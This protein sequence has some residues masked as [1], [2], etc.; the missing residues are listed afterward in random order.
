MFLEHKSEREAKLEEV[1]E[2]EERIVGRGGFGTVR[3]ARLR[4]APAVVRAVKTVWKRNLKAQHLVRQEIDILR[5][6]DH[7]CICRL[8]ETFEDEKAIYLVMEFIDG[9]E[10]FDEIVESEFLAEGQAAMIMRQVFSALQYCHAR[11]VVHRDL[12]PDNLMV[13]R[14]EGESPLQKEGLLAP[15]VKLIDF[16]LAVITTKPAMR[17]S[18]TGS[19]M[20]GT[21]DYMAPEVRSRQGACRPSSDVWSAGMV[22]HAL[23]VGALPD[24]DMMDEEEPLAF[25][26]AQYARVS[27]V[28]KDLLRGLLQVDPAKRLTAIMAASHPFLRQVDDACSPGSDCL[29]ATLGSFACFH[30][31][32]KLRRAALTAVAMQLT[33]HQLQHLRAQFMQIDTDG[34]GRISKEELAMSIALCAPGG[35]TESVHC[36][37]EMVFDSLDTDGSQEIDYTEWLAAALEEGAYRSEEALRAA[38]RVFDTD[39]DGVI[40]NAELGKLLA[41]SPE[42][43]AALLPQ[44]DANGDGVLDFEEFKNIFEHG[45]LP[46]D[47]AQCG[48]P[49]SP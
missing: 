41:E 6:L 45:L 11:N 15:E 5:T 21:A 49:L 3:K 7:P 48:S 29:A 36:F 30:K 19:T 2:V 23:L 34:N 46:G 9:R 8:Y 32:S 43:I 31:A 37:V 24:F 44:F 1:Y 42:E 38:F 35:N 18:T 47:L 16:G 33:S 28:A 14:M 17:R 26:H 39:G 40:D 4:T 13:Q 20:L 12:K 10:L 27:E 25:S 22:L